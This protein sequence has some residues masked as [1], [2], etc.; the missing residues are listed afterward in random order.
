MTKSY[1]SRRAWQPSYRK[2][3]LNETRATRNKFR[4]EPLLVY[5]IGP[6]HRHRDAV[7]VVN[8]KKNLFPPRSNSNN[9]AKSR[10]C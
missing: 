3:A 10:N 2:Q 6:S 9:N 7:N 4:R 1:K 5:S 8:Q